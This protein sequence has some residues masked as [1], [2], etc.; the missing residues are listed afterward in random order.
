[1]P[2]AALTRTGCVAIESMGR[3]TISDVAALSGVS[4]KTVS[5]VLNDEP[6]VRTETRA[7]VL[8]A[9][10]ELDYHPNLSARSLAG[11]RSYLIGLLY[12]NPSDNYVVDAQTGAMDRCTES[13]FNLFMFPC[14]HSDSDLDLQVAAMVNRTRLDGLIL[15]P[16]LSANEN[17][18]KRLDALGTPYVRV[19]P[20][21]FVHPSPFVAMDDRMAAREMTRHLAG[22]GH[23][24]IGFVIGH[25]DHVASNIRLEGYRQGL[26]D[27]GLRY[28]PGIVLQGDFNFASG[29]QCGS[30]FLRQS[31]PPTAIFASN[32]DMAA[33]VISALHE[34]GVD[35]PGDISV[36][37]FDDID[38]ARMVWPPLTTVHQPI[39]EMTHAA[40]G[41]LLDLVR[42]KEKPRSIRDFP[43]QIVVRESTAVPSPAA[44]RS[45]LVARL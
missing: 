17:L 30:E 38:A 10:R 24:R 7:A 32:D 45:D 40:A 25:P 39:Y 27:H 2:N 14:N 5:R 13:G 31:A 3:A 9:V 1:M 35:I 41:L 18:L 26:N 36:A 20:A 34:A 15:T 12:D 42:E 16:P 11:Q 28:E 8:A 23:Q 21:D 29:R 33:G 19:A 44:R 4:I 43:Y 37:G 22:L 6:H